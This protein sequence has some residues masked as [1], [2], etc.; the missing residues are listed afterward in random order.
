MKRRDF[1]GGT[2]TGLGAAAMLSCLPACRPKPG[3]VLKDH[4]NWAWLG[5]PHMADIEAVIRRLAPY[6]EA[7][8]SGLCISS[9]GIER[10]LPAAIELGFEVQAWTWMLCCP[11]RAV[12]EA[13]PNWYMINRKGESCLEKPA[14]V[15]YYRWLCPNKPEVRDFLLDRVLGIAGYQG[16]SAI[17]FDYMRYPDVIL[18]VGLQ[19]QYGLVQDGEM[20][21]FDY[22]YCPDCRRLFK[23]REGLDPLSLPDPSLNKAWRAF[24]EQ[25]I[26]DLVSFL[27][28][29]LHA[30]GKRV[31]AAVFPTPDIARGLVRQD[32]T[33][34]DL[35]D[36]FPMAYY[37]HYNKKASWVGTATA[38]VRE[39]LSGRGTKVYTGI[40]LNGA[41]KG[42]LETAVRA[43][44]DHGADGMAIFGDIREDRARPLGKLL[45]GSP[46]QKA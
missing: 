25:S 1:L 24:R 16:V 32:W 15:A 17:Q 2:L 46:N 8:I 4:K 18:P 10:T 36:I 7:G 30:R 27:A 37:A 21:E 6:R 13:H 29:E 14:Y 31:S 35:D 39:A 26:T 11:D 45:A 40:L 42:E 20:P 12:T 33:R 22:C 34:W 9:A 23:E 19:P 28:G 5:D 41:P 38:A 44:F 43:A 3:P